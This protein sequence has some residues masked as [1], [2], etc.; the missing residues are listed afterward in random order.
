MTDTSTTNASR[1]GDIIHRLL[2]SVGKAKPAAPGPPADDAAPYDWSAPA[3][4]TSRQRDKLQGL[5]AQGAKSAAGGLGAMLQGELSLCPMPLSQHFERQL[6]ASDNAGRIVTPLADAQNNICGALSVSAAK[7]GQWVRQFMGASAGAAGNTELSQLEESLLLDVCA[8]IV[9]GVWGAMAASGAPPI[10]LEPR[11]VKGAYEFTNNPTAEYCRFAF[12]D[13]TGAPSVAPGG[14]DVSPGATAA[15][16]A[17][18]SSEVGKS[19]AGGQGRDGPATHGRDARAT[20][21]A[22]VAAPADDSCVCLVI[23]T[24]LLM[25]AVEPPAAP[26]PPQQAASQLRSAVESATV[27]ATAILGV[28]RASV[29]DIMALEAGDVLLVERKVNEA[30]DLL[31]QGRHVLRGVPVCTDGHYGLEVAGNE[32]QA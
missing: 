19:S 27:N 14:A 16:S 17:A 32:P 29:R 30:I 5:L 15:P 22:P 6:A 24:D 10:A 9:K 31:V 20:G 26:T 23:L 1:P 28:A 7:A 8:A 21:Q 3:R 11:L 18:V 4:L 2:D 25:P 12:A 13:G